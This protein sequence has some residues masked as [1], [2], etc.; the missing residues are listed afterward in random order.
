MDE[1]GIV[2]V[3]LQGVALANDALEYRVDL[4]PQRRRHG[5]SIRAFQ[6][7]FCVLQS[8]LMVLRPGCS[9]VSETQQSIRSTIKCHFNC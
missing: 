4:S 1:A 9:D 3:A 2:S 5:K 7:C 8:E 6:S